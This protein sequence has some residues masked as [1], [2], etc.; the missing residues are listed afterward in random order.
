MGSYRT[1]L[2]DPLMYS[3]LRL[4]RRFSRTVHVDASLA[5]LSGS[6]GIGGSMS[7]THGFCALL[8]ASNVVGLQQ[9]VT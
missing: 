7:S 5:F 4:R 3:R 8:V 9:T 6:S 1:L 2:E